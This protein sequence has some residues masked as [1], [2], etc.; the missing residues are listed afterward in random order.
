M[1]LSD[2]IALKGVLNCH[3]PIDRQQYLP[4]ANLTVLAGM[5]RWITVAR[6]K[7]CGDRLLRLSH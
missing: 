1:H 3:F 6:G 5:H 7:L 2:V 4:A